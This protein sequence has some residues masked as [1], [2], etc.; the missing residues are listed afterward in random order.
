MGDEIIKCIKN[1]DAFY[2][3][4]KDDFQILKQSS[5]VN[6]AAA[7]E[8]LFINY[9]TLERAMDI[10]GDTIYDLSTERDILKNKLDSYGEYNAEEVK[11]LLQNKKIKQS[12]D[13][14]SKIIKQ[15]LL[16]TLQKAKALTNK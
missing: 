13:E 6:K 2:E 12:N 9:K 3:D 5:I 15:E 4:I 8:S 7:S 14:K 10:A 16:K 11:K 1:D